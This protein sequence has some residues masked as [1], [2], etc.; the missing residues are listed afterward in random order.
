MALLITIFIL[1]TGGTGEAWLDKIRD[2]FSG[3]KTVR[4]MTGNENDHLPMIYSNARG[5]YMYR[6]MLCGKAN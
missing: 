6:Y 5:Y 1:V 2:Y 4:V 3:L